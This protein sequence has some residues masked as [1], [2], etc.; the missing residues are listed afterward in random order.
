MKNK[1]IS[2]IIIVIIV[3]ALSMLLTALAII[4]KQNNNEKHTQN[5]E[6]E[7]NTLDNFNQ[8]KNDTPEE[9]LEELNKLYKK[10]GYSFIYKETKDNKII[11][12][13]INDTTKEVDSTYS[14]DID[15]QVFTISSSA[16]SIGTIPGR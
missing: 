2:V 1:K 15:K 16:T 10:E 13:Q 6:T 3:I 7:K 11:Y 8:E 12:E 5:E 9:V 4:N 14:Y